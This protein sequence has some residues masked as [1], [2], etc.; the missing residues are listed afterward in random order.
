MQFADRPGYE[1][2]R[3][4]FP[5][6]SAGLSDPSVLGAKLFAAGLIT[7]Y[8][9]QAALTQPVLVDKV[10]SLL[11][12]VMRQGSMGAFQ[13]F[14][15]MILQDAATAELGELLKGELDHP[16]IIS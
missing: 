8:T 9:K 11:E 16:D 3:E 13:R 5:R 7:E 10:T 2:L 15:E 14:A 4:F 6:L 12:G 1:T